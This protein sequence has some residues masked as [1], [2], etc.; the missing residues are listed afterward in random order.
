MKTI[1]LRA[2]TSAASITLGVLTLMSATTSIAAPRDEVLSIL[3]EVVA[4]ANGD[5]SQ[6]RVWANEGD[7]L[8]LEEGTPIA[9]HFQAREDVHLT[10]MYL[11]ADGNL[12]LLYPA[13]DGTSLTGNEQMDLEVG[14]ATTPYGQESLFVVASQQPITRASLGIDSADD[15]AVLEHDAAMEAVSKLRDIVAQG[16]AA[17]MPGARV[18]LHIVPARSTGQGYTRGGIVQYFTEATRS[19][20]RPKLNLDINFNSGS[21]EL[22]DDVRGDLDVVGQALSDERLSDKNFRLVGHT[23]HQGDSDYNQA[24][25]ESR[26]RAARAYLI[27]KYQ[28]DPARL[29]SMGLGESNPMMDGIDSQAMRRNRR[30]ELELIR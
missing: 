27:E 16:G 7:N 14:E 28:I 4:P 26:A 12:V 25:S 5:D 30:V 17:A 13:P 9:F 3:E 1:T 11:D 20:H 2:M 24:L 18:D 29:D 10:A 6:L 15:Y 23:D 22:M 21:A 8:P 19:L